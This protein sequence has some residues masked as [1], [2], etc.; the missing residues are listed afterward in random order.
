MAMTCQQLWREVS[1]YVDGTISPVIREEVERHLAYCR[2]CSA[3]VDGVR[4][5]VVLVADGRVFELPLGFNQR[6]RARLE[7]ELSS[8]PR[9]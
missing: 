2:H 1:N 7:K 6:L 3:V 8:P 9:P 4:N 5:V